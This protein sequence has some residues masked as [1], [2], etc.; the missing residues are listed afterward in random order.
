MVRLGPC[1]N[2]Q[3][4][5][6]DDDDDGN[7]WSLLHRRKRSMR[8]SSNSKCHHNFHILFHFSTGS[9]LSSSSF[10]DPHFPVD[11]MK[12][13]RSDQIRYHHFQGSIGSMVV[14]G[15]P[16]KMTMDSSCLRPVNLVKHNLIDPIGT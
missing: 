12:P 5:I 14:S 15:Q 2:N 3:M 8:R 7:C 4:T 16:T 1:Y 13:M 11:D 6:A 9:L 10:G